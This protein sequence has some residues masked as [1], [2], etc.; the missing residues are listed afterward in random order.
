MYSIIATIYPVDTMCQAH[1]YILYKYKFIYL[2]VKKIYA[3]FTIDEFI[4]SEEN[5]EAQSFLYKVI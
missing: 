2:S 4:V 3:V 1:S 5:N